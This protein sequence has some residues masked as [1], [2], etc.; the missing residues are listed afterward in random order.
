MKNGVCATTLK[1]GQLRHPLR[2]IGAALHRVMSCSCAG[3][4]SELQ[5]RDQERLAANPVEDRSPKACHVDRQRAVP[6]QIWFHGIRG[7]VLKIALLKRTNGRE[8]IRSCSPQSM[9]C[10]WRSRDRE[11]WR[12]RNRKGPER[13]ERWSSPADG[14]APRFGR[15]QRPWEGGEDP[16][17]QL[18]VASAGR[19]RWPVR[20]TNRRR[21]GEPCRPRRSILCK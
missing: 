5:M 18:P 11:R 17:C 3:G 20:L 2:G 15:I 13:R 12:S 4:R 9:K 7:R 6:S 16:G 21:P 14:A 19:G 8:L 10:D 1:A